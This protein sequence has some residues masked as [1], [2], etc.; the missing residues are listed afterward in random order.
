M[1]EKARGTIVICRFT[2][3]SSLLAT[4]TGVSGM[5]DGQIADLN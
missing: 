5:A 2:N 3:T 4:A 1:C